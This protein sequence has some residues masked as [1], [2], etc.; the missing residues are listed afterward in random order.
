MLERVGKVRGESAFEEFPNSA[1]VVE[2]PQAFPEIH[3]N[4]GHGG[5]LYLQP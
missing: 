4:E 2:L 5:A 1:D 3:N